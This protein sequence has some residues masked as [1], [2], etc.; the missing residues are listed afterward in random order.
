MKMEREM[1]SV[2]KNKGMEKQ[3]GTKQ[4]YFGWMTGKNVVTV[5][6]MTPNV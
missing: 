1:N 3:K 4:R 2:A 5:V 6:S